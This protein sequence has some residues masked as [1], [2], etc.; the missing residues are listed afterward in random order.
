MSRNLVVVLLGL[1]AWATVVDAQANKAATASR[2]A[3]PRTPWGDPD[4][5]G[6]YTNKYELNTPFERPKEFEGRRIEDVTGRGVGRNRQ[7]ASGTGGLQAGR[8]AGVHAVSRRVRAGEGE[9]AVARRRS[10]RRHG[11][12]RSGLTPRIARRRPTRAS[13][14]STNAGRSPEA[15]P[16]GR[17]TAR[18]IS[19][20]TIGASP[21]GCRARWCRTCR[22]TPI[23]SS[24]RRDS[25]RSGTS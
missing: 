14:P 23:R 4:L 19:A 6:T 3:P 1:C 2:Y 22:A 25:S 18:R 17:S 11:F 5:Q 13:T 12:R 21:E 8:S 10:A 15:L 20:S 9:P 16:A 7:A 24:R